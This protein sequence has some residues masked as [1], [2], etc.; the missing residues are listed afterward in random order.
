MPGSNWTSLCSSLQYR[1]L[2]SYTSVGAIVNLT[3][4][5]NAILFYT[6]KNAIFSI[7]YREITLTILK[8]TISKLVLTY[9]PN[10]FFGLNTLYLTVHCLATADN[11][12]PRS[13][14]FTSYRAMA[15]A[16]WHVLIRSVVWMEIK[17]NFQI[18]LYGARICFPLFVF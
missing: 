5:D 9:P 2:T 6:D 4:G 7:L 1:M 10:L 17:L 3:T 15:A 18:Y 14:S 11:G 13:Q 8:F 16:A 12:Q